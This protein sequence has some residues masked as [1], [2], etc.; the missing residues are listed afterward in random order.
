MALGAEVAPSLELL[1]DQ[2]QGLPQLGDLGQRARELGAPLRPALGEARPL[3]LIFGDGAGDHEI[4]GLD[5]LGRSPRRSDEARRT[6]AQMGEKRVVAGARDL[7]R[8]QAPGRLGF[9]GSGH[10]AVELDQQLT[11]AD[12]FAVADVDDPDGADLHRLDH[13]DVGD[14]EGLAA[15]DGDHVDLSEERPQK[16]NGEQ[17]AQGQHQVAQA[18]ARR[19]L[20]DLERR[21]EE[22]MLLDRPSVAVGLVLVAPRLAK[23]REVPGQGREALGDRA[24]AATPICLR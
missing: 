23:H 14:G 20:H 5:D 13:L 2:R 6:A 4:L 18:G 24:H 10:G 21:R 3:R 1:V 7:G 17:G 12:P 9:L 8:E 15:G 16:G 22:F 19:L 11:L